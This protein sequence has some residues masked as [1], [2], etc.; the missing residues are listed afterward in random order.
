MVR[1]YC[2]FRNCTYLCTAIATDK[3]F[4]QCRIAKI[5][6]WCNGSTTDFGSV[7]LGSNP[8]RSTQ[9]LKHRLSLLLF[10]PLKNILA[11]FV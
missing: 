4:S 5:D 7:C 1:G 8:G 10:T 9:R 11:L 3:V 6:L 2:R